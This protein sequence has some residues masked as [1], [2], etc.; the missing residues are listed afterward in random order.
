MPV[1]CPATGPCK[2]DAPS[3]GAELVVLQGEAPARPHRLQ[4]RRRAE[5]DV[6]VLVEVVGVRARAGLL[7]EDLTAP[8]AQHL[9]EVA[10]VGRGAD[11]DP[12]GADPAG[13]PQAADDVVD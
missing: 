11:L 10:L 3:A 8:A 1:P 12:L 2:R 6:A 7:P 5:R 4:G 13:T 9:L